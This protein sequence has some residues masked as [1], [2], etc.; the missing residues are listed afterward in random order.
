MGGLDDGRVEKSTGNDEVTQTLAKA[1]WV[2]RA[3]G[4]SQ[5]ARAMVPAGAAVLEEADS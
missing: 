3:R 5:G 4:R 1:E 2:C